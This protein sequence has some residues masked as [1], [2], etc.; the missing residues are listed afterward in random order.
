LSAKYAT[1]LIAAAGVVAVAQQS[2]NPTGARELF[3]AAASSTDKLPPA[4]SAARPAPPRSAP[5]SS[6]RPAA[7]RVEP[8]PRTQGALVPASY[9]SDAG[10]RHLGLRYNLVI[11]DPVSGRS[12]PVA[13]DRNFATGECFAIEFESNRSGYLYVLARQS[14][15]NWMPLFPSPKMP[16]ESN[17]I[18]PGQKVRV[19]NRYCFEITDP[20]GTEKLFVALSRDPRENQELHDGVKSYAPP[21]G[22]AAKPGTV[23]IADA[24]LVNSAVER[25]SR[26]SYTRDLAIRK[27]G[28]PLAARE[29]AHSVYVVNASEKSESQL[30]TEI[31][32]H[33]R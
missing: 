7:P 29:P 24:R 21:A 10:V 20:P 13:S 33:H 5:A 32:V 25:M 14:S 9:P 8:Q 27:I 12:V 3:Y 18:D 1:V 4:P 19:P 31:E 6:G 16:D 11:V 15:G 22:D 28:Q 17:V 26:Q 30:V 23:L 2:Q